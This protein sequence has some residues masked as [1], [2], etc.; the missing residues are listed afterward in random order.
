MVLTINHY[1]FVV[2]SRVVYDPADLGASIWMFYPAEDSNLCEW[3]VCKLHAP[4]LLVRSSTDIE[5]DFTMHTC[6]FKVVCRG[7]HGADA[8]SLALS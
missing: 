6:K 8:L 5:C 2:N 3:N 4:L 1:R 7:N